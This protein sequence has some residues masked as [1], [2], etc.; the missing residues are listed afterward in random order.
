VEDKTIHYETFILEKF[1]SL[2]QAC[3][4]VNRE[5]SGVFVRCDPFFSVVAEDGYN[6]ADF[7][8]QF[9]IE[10]NI[11]RKLVLMFTKISDGKRVFV[12]RLDDEDAWKRAKVYCA[13]LGKNNYYGVSDG[14]KVMV[15]AL[16]PSAKFER[17]GDL[18][19]FAFLIR[20]IILEERRIKDSEEFTQ[21]LKGYFLELQPSV[22]SALVDLLKNE[23]FRRDLIKFLKPIGMAPED[24]ELPEET[25]GMISQQ[26]TYLL[27]DKLLFLS[28]IAESRDQLLPK[29]SEPL[30]EVVSEVNVEWARRF[31]TTLEEKFK[32]IRFINYEPIFDPEL[33]PLNRISL[34]E[35][36]EGC[37]IIKDLLAYLR[38]KRGLT[39]LFEGPLLSRIYE[40][41]IPPDLRWK[42]GQIYTPPE[43]T[44]LIA[45]WAIR[46]P[47]DKVLD[48]ACGTGRFLV[49]A[50]H[51]LSELKRERG[52][53]PSHQELLNQLYGIDINQFPAHLATM[54]LVSL[55]LTSVTD[56]V[57]IKVSD[58]FQYQN[59]M[60]T[61]I[62][63]EEE[64]KVRLVG[65][66]RIGRK[67]SLTGQSKLLTEANVSLTRALIPFDA[68]LMNPPYTRQEALGSYKND[69]RKVALEIARKGKPSIKVPMSKR[70]GYY[71]YFMTHGT[72]FLKE[73]GR[74]G[75]IVQNSWLDVDYGRDVQR[76]LLENYKIIAVIDCSKERFIKT[77]DVNTVIV[78]LEKC[79]GK[80]R[81]EERDGN[82]VHFVDLRKPLDWFESNY[83]FKELIELIENTKENYVDNDLRIIVK[84][85]NELWEEGLEEVEQK[86]GT[87]KLLY[88][89]SKWGKYLRA[90]DIYFKI[91]E[92]GKDLFVPLKE[93]AEVRRGFTTGAN[94][95]FYLPN[96]YFDI[97]EDGEELVLLD[98]KTGEERF[99]I[100]RE[101]WMHKEG[102]NFVPN[103]VIKSTR[104]CRALAI[105][106]RNLE[107]RVLMIHKNREK[108]KGT[109]ILR[110][111]KFG[112]M[113]RFNKRPTCSS[114][115]RWYDLGDRKPTKLLFL[116]ATADRPA[117][118][119]CDEAVLH[120]QTFYSIYPKDETK[121]KTIAALLNSSLIGMFLR[122]VLSGAGAALGLGALWSAVFE[123]ERLPI[124]DPNKLSES[125]LQILSKS[126]ER[127]SKRQINA[128]FKEIGASDPEDVSLDKVKKDRRELD[129]IVM[130]EILGLSKREQLEVYRGIVRLV[131][132][133]LERAKTGG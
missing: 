101:F 38:G 86:D 119:I 127:L 1:N 29:I 55:D 112:E 44:R 122:E 65:Q 69:V 80:E 18:Q 114:R 3:D 36:V 59:Y 93:V 116:R 23:A 76:F 6:E 131:K 129:E 42:W 46:S 125:E 74:F 12:H 20:D 13:R 33:S 45:E 21:K 16:D 68:I 83:G 26:S 110:Y 120:D 128:V 41:L 11:E 14:Q 87:K 94:E 82:L 103:Y 47:D 31:W 79:M 37:L 17:T 77:A 106:V 97:R 70:A 104:D 19:D 2:K 27:I 108:L 7:L 124:I 5:N 72:N 51:K 95:F 123:V 54:S 52:E 49:S 4:D 84:T 98:K 75:M 113:K 32:V 22:Y 111:I 67:G 64:R 10:P 60:Q 109:K 66:T 105:D 48:P 28:L 88:S 132:E 50:Y 90:P 39:K 118:Y 117:T 63:G 8:F 73:N 30:P 57:N 99:R 40:G 126:F 115:E 9:M 56:E 35:D 61:K 58:F 96:K 25:I 130:G 85:Q 43:V 24:D 71:V 91:L 102:G 15:R 81:V 92:K 53:E 121:Y 78:F 89:G 100:E 34:R 133:R 107:H 62:G